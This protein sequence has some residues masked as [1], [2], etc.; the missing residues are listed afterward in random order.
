M[1]KPQRGQMPPQKLK[2]TED[3]YNGVVIP[4][5]MQKGM[6]LEFENRWAGELAALARTA[7]GEV[8]DE[9]RVTR[10]VDTTGSWLLT[11][12]LGAIRAD[13]VPI[14]TLALH[15]PDRENL[16]RVLASGEDD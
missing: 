6:A 1:I 4:F 8:F 14:R 15:R 7:Q 5:H 11:V 9:A 10:G 16:G 3:V 13:A 12:R 2:K